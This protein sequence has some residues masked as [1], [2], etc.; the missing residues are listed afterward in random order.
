[1]PES[2]ADMLSYALTTLFGAAAGILAEKF[3]NVSG[4]LILPLWHG[5]VGKLYRRRRNQREAKLIG[6][7]ETF[8][9]GAAKHQ[10]YVRQFSP[11]GFAPGHLKASRVPDQP[12]AYLMR[13]LREPLRPAL[14]DDLETAIEAKRLE[15]QS[16]PEAWNAEKFA[17]RRIRVSRTGNH[18]EP[19]IDLGYAVTDYAAFQVVAG[20]WERHYKNLDGVIQDLRA[21]DLWDVLPGLSNSFGV[22][23]TLET[24][25]DHLL[26]ARRSDKANSAR[27]LRHVAVNEGMSLEDIDPRTDLPDPYLTAVRGIEEELGID[28]AEEPGARGRITF[29]SL[30]CD[31]T[32]YEWAL[33]GHVDL[34]QTKWTNAA[35]QGA[36]KLGA[37]PDDWESNKLAFVPFDAK[38]IEAVLEDDSDWVGHGY[39]NVLLSAIFRLRS[40]RAAFINRARETLMRS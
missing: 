25:D 27:N 28:L 34:R 13:N 31:V 10:I 16:A 12:A 35:I 21:D 18:E 3:L 5:T 6:F 22:N 9:V 11:R 38:S 37:A 8:S 19:T 17:L 15:L 4:R 24:A 30:V 1:M 14:P 23:L 39:I 2:F 7:S 33:L 32:R 29:H 40:N 36:R 26:L 20:A